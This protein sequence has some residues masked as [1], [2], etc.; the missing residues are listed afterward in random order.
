MILRDDIIVKETFGDYSFK[1][2]IN[3]CFPSS[4][5]SLISLFPSFID[6]GA[7]HFW[8]LGAAKG[9]RGRLAKAAKRRFSSLLTFLEKRE[10]GFSFSKRTEKIPLFA[11]EGL[12]EL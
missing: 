8:P 12:G 1:Q 11:K 2:G 10:E 3:P 7:I 9:S 6:D 5:Y 4:F